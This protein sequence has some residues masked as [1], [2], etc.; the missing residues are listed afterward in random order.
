MNVPET[1][2]R[3]LRALPD[4][5]V[6]KRVI[7]FGK[8]SWVLAA[9]L[10]ALPSALLFG[11]SFYLMATLRGD[12]FLLSADP[13]LCLPALFLLVF[14]SIVLHELIHGLGFWWFTRTRPRFGCTLW[15]A[16]AAAPDWYLPRNQHLIVGLLPFAT[17]T[18]IG[19][20]LLFVVPAS[21]A[22]VIGG[23]LVW[24]AAGAT[25][26]LLVA[27]FEILETRT[28]LIQDAG[29]RITFYWSG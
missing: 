5:Y 4:G 18:S 23:L 26:D 28:T 14:S 21:W 15:G 10:L 27:F 1:V 22:V 2:T 6:V 13:S 24:N 3:P 16:Y 19:V 29:M 17:I 12:A 11:A 25:G 9:N 8:G 20:L 7:D